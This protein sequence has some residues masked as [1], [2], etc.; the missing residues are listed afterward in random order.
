[1]KWVVNVQAVGSGAAALKYLAAYVSRGPLH[2][3]RIQSWD[4]STVTFRY[5]HSNG[6]EHHCRVGGEEFVRRLLQH[7]PPKGFQRVRH[8]GWLSGP[9]NAQWQC[10]LA[11]L[12]WRPP[13]LN[14]LPQTLNPSY[15]PAVANPCA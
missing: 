1:M 14:C 7:V 10:I 4:G 13:C 12:D 3:S 2:P 8:Y 9:A 5:R 11:L 6:V 15:A